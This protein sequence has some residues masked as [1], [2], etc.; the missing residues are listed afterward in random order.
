MVEN[1]AL[2]AN[3]EAFAHTIVFFSPNRVRDSEVRT[4]A[5]YTAI[6][7]LSLFHE[8]I[9]AKHGADMH[10]CFSCI[11]IH[12]LGLPDLLQVRG[13]S[14]ATILRGT[15]TVE[16]LT[17]MASITLTGGS[18]R[19]WILI[20]VVEVFKYA[21]H[22]LHLDARYG[23]LS[24][25]Y[26]GGEVMTG[27][28][29]QGSGSVGNVQRP[30]LENGAGARRCRCLV[31]EWLCTC[32]TTAQCEAAVRRDLQE[33]RQTQWADPPI[34]TATACTSKAATDTCKICVC[35]TPSHHTPSSLL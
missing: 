22:S 11:A 8:N 33:D 26:D 1:S 25:M 10:A 35:R 18:P 20:V 5:V 12:P 14:L 24:A 21:G 28:L 23:M 6:N 16:V 29:L 19:K 7:L 31:A 17:E 2:I 32:W 34:Q 30:G 13:S 4:E 27:S 3:I 15:Q 9:R